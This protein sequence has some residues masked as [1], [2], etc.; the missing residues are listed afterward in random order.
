MENKVIAK[1]APGTAP[2]L[3]TIQKTLPPGGSAVA[4]SAQGTDQG[5]GSA[6]AN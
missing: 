4:T 2:L 5:M 3:H 6:Q 1:R